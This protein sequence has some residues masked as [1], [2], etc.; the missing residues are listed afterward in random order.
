MSLFYAKKIDIL[1]STPGLVLKFK[2]GEEIL[3]E[4]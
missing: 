4:Y 1:Q 2:V 3:Q